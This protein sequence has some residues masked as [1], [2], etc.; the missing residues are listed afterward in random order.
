M[1]ALH[2]SDINGDGE[3]EILV[4][5]ADGFLYLLNRQGQYIDQYSIDYPIHKIFVEDIDGDG[6]NEILVA[7]DNKELIALTYL[8]RQE[9]KE[10]F[11]KKWR[12]YFDKRLLALCVTDIDGDGNKEIIVSSED[13]HIYILDNKGNILWRH[14]YRHRIFSIFPVDLNKDELPELLIGT[15]D[16][17]HSSNAHP[18]E[19]R[20][21]EKNLLLL[22][23]ATQAR[24]QR[25]CS[26]PGHPTA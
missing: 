23:K 22:S 11:V 1:R 6:E 26:V 9:T 3:A 20:C 12:S 4:G 19:Q 13:K 14:D 10:S 25:K 15:E 2:C 17:L 8:E 21:R 18:V 5:S 7:S 24:S 16:N